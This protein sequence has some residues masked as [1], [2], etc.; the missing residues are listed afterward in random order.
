[1]HGRENAVADIAV[2]SYSQEEFRELR[3]R[4]HELVRQSRNRLRGKPQL[5]REGRSAMPPFQPLR[6][7]LACLALA[8][9]L[10]TGATASAETTLEKIKRTGVITA[11]NTFSY[12]PF[13]F[14]EDGKQVGFDVD[15]GNEIARRMGARM[16]FEAV[17]FRGI[18]AA[19]TSGRVDMLITGMVYTPDRAERI[20]FSEPYFDGG[21]AA[22]FRPDKPIAKPD[23]IIGK[24][25][26]VEIGS[27]GDKY[28]REKYGSRV[29]MKTYDT[30][31]LALKDLENGRLDVFVGSIAPMRYIMRN[32]PTVKATELWDSRIQA[33]NTRKEDKDLLQE[34]N[35]HL[36]AMKRDGT[37]DTLV[38][39]WFG[40]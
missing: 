15:L 36:T 34:I 27:A 38:K 2:L 8:L 16:A 24:R 29:E 25:V 10:L 21:V 17:D 32:M 6:S 3:D 33:A 18:I 12:P 19:L 40:S 31:F 30:V 23:D 26:G 1:L 13:G 39:K 7:H 20:D 5:A 4:I 14:I 35:K 28:V 11:A 37:Y 22:A 9:L